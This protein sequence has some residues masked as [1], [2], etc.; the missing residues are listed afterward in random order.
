MRVGKPQCSQRDI[1]MDP[2]TS[3]VEHAGPDGARP[4]LNDEFTQQFQ[5]NQRASA[6]LTDRFFP[7]HH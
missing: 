5:C 2:P 3:R 7:T 6:W 4:D 1:G